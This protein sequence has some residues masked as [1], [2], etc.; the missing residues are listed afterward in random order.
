[1]QIHSCIYKKDRYVHENNTP[2][3]TC[4]KYC[5]Y[6]APE[7]YNNF[8]NIEKGGIKNVICFRN[9]RFIYL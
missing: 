9:C 2:L 6:F 4:M 8:M 5:T 1:M 7:K 3:D